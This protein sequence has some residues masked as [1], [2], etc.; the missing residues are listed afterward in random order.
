MRPVLVTLF[1]FISASTY[2]DNKASR[3]YKTPNKKQSRASVD[4]CLS[5][6][7]ASLF[8]SLEISPGSTPPKE[9]IEKKDPPAGHVLRLNA[10]DIICGAK[11]VT[12]E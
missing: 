2:A 12:K 3:V 8:K 7:Y 5:P 9:S 6:L 4:P 1:L 10:Y 11:K